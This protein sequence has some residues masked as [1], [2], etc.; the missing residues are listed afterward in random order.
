MKTRSDRPAPA[1]TERDEIIGLGSR[2]L[3]KNYFGKLQKHVADLARFRELLDVASDAIVVAELPDYRIVDAN[4]AARALFPGAPEEVEGR[5]LAS[6]FPPRVWGRL[7]RL[8]LRTARGEPPLLRLGGRAG[9]VF[10]VALQE[11]AFGPKRY[12]VVIARDVTERQRAA[13]ALMQAKDEAERIAR[14]KSEFLSIA[15]HELRT[16]VT[17]LQ[18]WL[19]KAERSSTAAIPPAKLLGPVRRLVAIVN[20]LLEVSRLERRDLHPRRVVLDLRRV[21]SQVVEDFHA[22]S[23]DHRF[24]LVDGPP[25]MAL[26]DPV[27]AARVVANVVENAVKFSPRDSTVAVRVWRNGESACV[28]VA[29]RGP[30]IPA[31]ERDR[32]FAPFSRLVDT[33]TIPGLGLGL[34]MSRQLTR[35]QGG[36]VAVGDTPGGGAT[37]TV[38]LPAAGPRARRPLVPEEERP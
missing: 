38:S 26:A 28:A 21:V 37:V 35:M 19:Q 5:P 20:E 13:R 23:P 24:E 27:R 36:D 4:R 10:A 34:F 17:A 1:R 8:V 11:H 9:R 7:E 22:R 3:R 25:V 29:D 31:W 6:F 32:L 12:V 2:S 33:R 15:S 30:G 16:P 14:V 18:L